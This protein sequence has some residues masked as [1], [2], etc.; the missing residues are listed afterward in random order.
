M[1]ELSIVH[2]IL[3]IVQKTVPAGNSEFVSAVHMQVGELSS[4]E[5]DALLFAFDAVK[6]GT[7][8]EAAELNIAIVKGEAECSNCNTTFHLKTYG[9]A[10]PGC[11][12]YAVR[13][14]KGTEMKIVSITMEE[15]P[16]LSC[17]A[18]HKN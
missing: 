13:V 14:L 8:L 1:H 5:T 7:V 17:L 2:S 3:S 10:C 16:A 12:G 9:T 4:I 15:Q 6:T 18:E 11:N